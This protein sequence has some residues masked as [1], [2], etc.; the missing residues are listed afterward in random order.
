MDIDKLVNAINRDF[1]E[2]FLPDGFV[3][4]ERRAD[5]FRLKIGNRDVHFDKEGNV[6]GAGT[7]LEG[8]WSVEK[9]E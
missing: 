6:M 4:A 1:G 2:P 7:S 9:H 5:G 3:D 8:G